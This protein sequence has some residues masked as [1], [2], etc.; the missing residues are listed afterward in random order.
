MTDAP[1]GPAYT[2][3][4]QA[5]SV[6][7]GDTFKADVDLG[8]HVHAHWDLRL[9]GIN[10]PELKTG[11]PGIEARDALAS[12]VVGALFVKPLLVCTQKTKAGED[13]Q[14]FTRYVA[15]VWVQAPLGEWTDVCQWMV[16]NG[17]AV[18]EY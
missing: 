1:D 16:D 12:L 9:M 2:Y 8:G 17:H 18:W 5:I 4:A 15:Q 10:A 13:I 14:S 3:R 7:D 6:H 11:A